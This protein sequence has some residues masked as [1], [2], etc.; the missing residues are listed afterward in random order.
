ELSDFFY[1]WEKR[2]LGLIHPKLFATE[3]TDKQNEAVA[4]PARFADTGKRKKE[5]A[6]A[7]YEAKMA[8]IF[9]ECSRVLRDD[10]V[11]TVMFTHKRAEAWD[12][13][14]MGLL[15]AGFRIETSWPVNTESEQ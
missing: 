7:D 13:L 12:T 2:T 14:G 8:A 15:Q 3:L 1:V 5:L 4:N 6:N 10:G 9:A 11:L